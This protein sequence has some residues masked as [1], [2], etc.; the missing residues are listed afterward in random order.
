MTPLAP[1]V[2]A[3]LRER[4]PI[5]RRASEHT[6]DT[7]AHA[8]RLLFQYAASQLKTTPS[9]LQLEQI[10]AP[11][12]L[13]F[14]EHIETERG[15]GPTTRNSRLAAIKS[16]MHYVE[17]K[18]PS[19]LEQV[20]QILVLPSKKTQTRLV[21]HLTS[22]EVQ[23]I[24]DAPDPRLRLGTRDRAMLHVCLAAGLRVSELVGLRL[25]DV[26]FVP[27]PSIRVLGKGRRE[28]QLPLWK[29]TGA[30]LRAWLAIRGQAAVPEV[31]L[32]AAGEAMTR[33]GLAYVLKRH[34]ASAKTRC[35]SLCTKR[36]FP[37][38]MRHTCAMVTLKA[39][40]DIRKVALWL[41]HN[42]LQTTEMYLRADPTEKLEVVSA[43]T[44]PALRKGRFHAPDQLIEMLSGH[45]KG[46]DYAKEKTRETS[47]L[48]P[49]RP[50]TVHNK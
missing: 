15:N 21:S 44:P 50:L 4:L 23:A 24:L 20:R 41:G 47:W 34:V 26:T 32:N 39:T 3:F 35:P 13:R 40:K 5:E 49:K 18:V 42:S 31:F 33:A 22:E 43:I 7:Y 25:E 45:R 12:V 28:R 48:G 27:R 16:F 2:T 10:D 14:L 38:L 8:F 19:A 11:L 37:H 30:A 1:H 36:V 6:C 17:Y 29:E 9:Q 46:N